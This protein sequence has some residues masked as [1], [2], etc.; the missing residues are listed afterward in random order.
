MKITHLYLIREILTYFLIGVLVFT[1]LFI[2]GK[3]LKLT[4]LLVNQGV[5]PFDIGRLLIYLLPSSLIFMIPIGL[6]L[7]VL[8]TFVRLSSDNEIVAFKASGVSLYQLT[9]PVLFLSITAY[10][11]TTLLVIYGLPWGSQGF[12]HVLYDIAKTKAYTAVK[13]GTFNDSFDGI[14][15]YVDKTPLRGKKLRKIFIHSEDKEESDTKTILAKEGYVATNPDSHEI[16]LHLIGVTGDRISKEGES[17]T[18]IESDALIQKLTFGGNLSRIRRFRARDWEMSIGELK[19]KVKTRKLLHKDYTQQLLEIYRKFSIP[20][21]C[22]VFGLMG[23]PLGVQPRRSGRS[24]GFILG[25]P[26]VLAYYMLRTL[27]ETFAFNGTLP[28]LIASWTPNLILMALAIYLLVKT[29]NESPIAILHWSAQIME[30]ITR[31]IKTFSKT[32]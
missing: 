13:E 8:T 25:I 7:G 4:E 21:A 27:A 28:P 18:S 6:L 3:T 22:I 17:Y 5:S 32:I 24:Y 20:F 19:A 10:L 11:L 14:V 30:S 2:M 9:P 29:A 12:R 15:I 26:V 23:I 31:S 1:I 16:I